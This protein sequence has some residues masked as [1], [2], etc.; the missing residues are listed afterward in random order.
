MSGV[1]GAINVGKGTSTGKGKVPS[2]PLAPKPKA[3]SLQQASA[4][5]VKVKTRDRSNF[6]ACA[7]R[8]KLQLSAAQQVTVVQEASGRFDARQVTLKLYRI[9]EKFMI[10]EMP[11]DGKEDLSEDAVD[12]TVF[13]VRLVEMFMEKSGSVGDVERDRV[14][15][16]FGSGT[17]A[18]DMWL[19]DAMSW[20]RGQ[21]AN[22]RETRVPHVDVVVDKWFATDEECKIPAGFIDNKELQAKQHEL[23]EK[24]ASVQIESLRRAELWAANRPLT[25]VSTISWDKVTAIRWLMGGGGGCF[26]VRVE[27]EKCIVKGC[28]HEGD[29]LAHEFFKIIGVRVATIR[30]ISPSATEFQT[31]SRSLG[32]A[33]TDEPG[34]RK[35][36]ESMLARLRTTGCPLMVMEFVEGTSLKDRDASERLV[37]CD[38]ALLHSL[39]RI[40]AVDSL[41][42]NWDRLPAL[43][44]WPH[45]GNLDNVLIA[46]SGEIVAI[47][48]ALQLL[49]EPSVRVDYFR[50][51]RAFVNEVNLANGL[52]GNGLGRT[53][54][55][56]RHQV[57]KWT[58]DP[59]RDGELQQH[60][61][62]KADKDGN[63]EFG[64]DLTD[65]ASNHL[66]DGVRDIF[67]KIAVVRSNFVS[68]KT[69]VEH[70]KGFFAE[71]EGAYRCARIEAAASFLE[72]CLKVV[73]SEDQYKSVVME[74]L[75]QNIVYP[76]LVYVHSR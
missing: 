13:V 45:K 10:T 62:I 33:E 8:A 49:S 34:M 59:Q 2:P 17:V 70:A 50:A 39:G 31:A 63:P 55:A 58:G 41:L 66:L 3:P 16:W 71:V 67:S 11:L 24:F 40:L 23:N 54:L 1:V 5:V 4:F 7:K 25:D 75:E 69:F 35:Y 20:L 48:Q 18:R 57:M 60:F 36:L 22:W 73:E 32:A 21:Q 9:W 72:N 37:A 76:G 44:T 26:L 12:A 28:L 53:K 43:R 15:S 68:N 6:S 52:D 51:L 19:N 29:V 56:I 42:N 38:K 47:D 30:F 14:I 46:K 64:V 27:D 74:T 65:A 61:V